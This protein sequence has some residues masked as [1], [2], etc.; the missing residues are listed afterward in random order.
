MSRINTPDA[1]PALRSLLQRLAAQPAGLVVSQHHTDPQPGEWYAGTMIGELGGGDLGPY[2]SAEDALV[3]G[4][5][6]LYELVSAAQLDSD[7]TGRDMSSR[8][9]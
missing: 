7:Q 9:P 6:W 5:A 8:C 2:P 3:A 4:V 1:P